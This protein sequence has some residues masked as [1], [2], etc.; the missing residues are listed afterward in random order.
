MSGHCEGGE[1]DVAFLSLERIREAAAIIDPVF[2][3]SPQFLCEGLSRRLNLRL[4]CKVETVNPIRSFKGRG[5]DY[6]LHR[7]GVADAPLACASAGN[8]GQGLAYAA[9]RRGLPLHVFAATGANPLKIERM[10]DLGARVHLA[11]GDFD[12]AKA[13]AREVAAARGWRFVEDG[14]EA[15]IAEGAGT[16]AVELT[17]WLEPF[18]AVVVPVGNGALINGIGRWLKT[19][20]PTTRIIGV[21]AAG[22]PTMARSW[23]AQLPLPTAAVATVADGIAVRVPVPAAVAEM[24][25]TTDDV[26][27][28]GDD[29]IRE[30]MRLL[31]H[32]LGLVVEPAG[33]AGLAGVLVLR[34][35]LRDQLVATPLCG[36]NVAPEHLRR[37]LGAE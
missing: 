7:L 23:Q 14:A 36:G 1:P 6:L 18:D 22:A 24:V 5:A 19:H 27:L 30:A 20:A 35:Q 32:E 11:G 21:C 3:D 25:R 28:V 17:R 15:A 2:T 12:A 34:D 16:I 31:F 4:V 37:L 10:R 26:V 13:H 9:R 8:F 33:A 29:T